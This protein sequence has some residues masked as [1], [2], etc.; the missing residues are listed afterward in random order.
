[1]RASRAIRQ[2]TR[3]R[4]P[5]YMNIQ[6]KL[7]EISATILKGWNVFDRR[8]LLLRIARRERYDRYKL[9]LYWRRKNETARAEQVL[10][11][12][13]AECLG[14]RYNINVPPVRC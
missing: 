13:R 10:L 1:M 11:R 5:Y 9:L 12:L 6:W 3:L 14:C 4:A 7:D 8:I 2:L